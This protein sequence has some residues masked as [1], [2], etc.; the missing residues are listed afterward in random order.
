[1]LHNLYYEKATINYV[2]EGK[3]TKI[4]Y[5]TKKNKKKFYSL[6]RTRISNAR[7]CVW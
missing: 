2:N 1:M 4:F 7:A 5:N 3:Y 6:A